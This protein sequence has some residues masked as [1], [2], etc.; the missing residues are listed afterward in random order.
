VQSFGYSQLTSSDTYRFSGVLLL[1]GETVHCMHFISS[2]NDARNNIDHSNLLS[3][4]PAN[5]E[6]SNR[7]LTDSAGNTASFVTFNNFSINNSITGYQVRFNPP[8]TPD[9]FDNFP[10]TKHSSVANYD[11]WPV[12]FNQTTGNVIQ[13]A[14]VSGAP[15]VA[16]PNQ[17]A[18]GR[19]RNIF[20]GAGTTTLTY[21]AVATVAS[22]NYQ[23]IGVDSGNRA[24]FLQNSLANDFTQ[25]I[26]R[27]N[28]GVNTVT[29]LNTF[30][31]S[32][33]PSGT[34][35]GGTR[36]TAFGNTLMKFSSKTFTD[37]NS[38]VTKGW[39]TPYLDVNGRYQPFYY[40]WNTATDVF[41]RNSDLSVTYPG[42]TT[43]STYWLP[44]TIS[45]A[46]SA[47][48][49]AAQRHWYNE[50]FVFGGTRF[51]TL[52]QLHGSG[53][54]LD[55]DA[56]YRTFMTYSI[57]AVD[58]KILTYH[59]SVTIPTTPKNTIW[60]SDDRT[61][62]GVFG[63]NNFWIYK[64]NATTG[65]TLTTN[66]PYRFDAVGRDS[67]GRIWAVDGG[68][69]LH[70]RL[71]LLTAATPSTVTV[72]LAQNSY[73]YQGVAID[74]TAI[75]NAYNPSGERI[76]T[77]INL[78]IEG[79]SLRL[80]NQATQEVGELSVATSSSADTSVPIRIVGAGTS[81]IIT[82]INI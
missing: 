38:E 74:S 53:A 20:T 79:T 59:S 75:V 73:N 37:P 30:N 67:L 41:T 45:A 10:P 48:V 71:H 31:V 15:S 13:I 49:Y 42:S 35:A 52:F 57:D 60:L 65:W 69:L 77:T 25:L 26:Q 29:T 11:S 61:L 82:S 33:T 80:I 17:L 24:I 36:G 3:M 64:F 23:F 43:Q 54:V 8:N 19:I 27:Y 22:V 1:T 39:Y 34:S 18:P 81:N 40:Q 12:W 5:P 6:F 4:D 76:A 78:R 56:R 51:I 28:D 62:L 50:T 58:P 55:G 7:T 14:N 47:T 46:G 32:P 66:L 21:E 63:I 9:A 70:G 16:F 2:N 44:D 72:S 68:P